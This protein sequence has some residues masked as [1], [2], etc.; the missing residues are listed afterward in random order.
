MCWLTRVL[1]ITAIAAIFVGGESLAGEPDAAELAALI[2][3][4]VETR[5][6]AERLR[7]AELADDAEFLRR[8]YLDLHGVVPTAEQAAGFLGD[9]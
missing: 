6:Q 5:L 2:D 3:R 9:S 4:Q 8:V 1:L 7:P